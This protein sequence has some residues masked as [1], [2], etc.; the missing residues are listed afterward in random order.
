MV[1][2]LYFSPS[3][4][5]KAI[6]RVNIWWGFNFKGLEFELSLPR[7]QELYKSGLRTLMDLWKAK[8]FLWMN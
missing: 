3:Q 8:T 5:A 4:V 2:K 7:V 6:K 1:K